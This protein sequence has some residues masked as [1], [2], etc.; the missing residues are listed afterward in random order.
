VV[1]ENLISN[2]LKHHDRNEG[3]ITVAARLVDGIAEFRVSDDGPGILP[4]FHHRI[5]V[6]FQ[7]LVGRDELE[8]IGI[9]LAIVKKKV[10]GHGGRV[11]VESAPPARGA[12]FAF[13]W[14]ESAT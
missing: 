13:T 4:E 8:S 14:M 7:T 11:W 2:A 12:T 6:I 10:E 9:G 5:F 3:C 1:L